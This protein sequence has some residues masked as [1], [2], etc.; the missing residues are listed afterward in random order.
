MNHEGIGLG[1]TIVK[2]I[3]NHCKG[4]IDVHSK[5]EGPGCTFRFSMKME[6]PILLVKSTSEESSDLSDE[7]I[8]QESHKSDKRE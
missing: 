2:Q 6:A 3:V 7:I 5:G 1:L 4:H 8:S